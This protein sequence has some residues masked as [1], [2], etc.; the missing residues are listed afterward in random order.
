[1]TRPALIYDGDCPFC[2]NY[3]GLVDLR[4]RWPDVELVDARRHPDHPAVRLVRKAG[5][6]IDD[7]MALVV[8]GQIHHGAAAMQHAHPMPEWLYSALKV[9]RTFVLRLLGRSKLGF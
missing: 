3:V 8:D 5:K 6:R 7:G 9:G 1:M 4:K 2:A